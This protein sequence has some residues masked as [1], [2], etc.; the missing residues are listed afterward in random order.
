MDINNFAV[1]ITK[2][3][4]EIIRRWFEETFPGDKRGFEVGCHFG[5]Q[6]GKALGR[7]IGYGTEGRP[8]I[9]FEEFTQYILNNE[10]QIY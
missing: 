1:C 3:N 5:K 9:S 10:Y 2:E 4:Q 6:G 7:G 8:I